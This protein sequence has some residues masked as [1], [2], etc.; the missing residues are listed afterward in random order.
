MVSNVSDRP[1]I[2]LTTYLEPS[3]HGVWDVVS[4]I[5][6]QAYLDGVSR[7]GGRPV[8]LPPQNAWTDDEID[9]LDGLILTGGADIDPGRYGQRPLPTSGTPQPGRDGSELDLL[10][11]AERKRLPVLG[12]C[13]GL[14]VIN[15]AHGGTLHQHLPDVLGH[16]GHQRAPGVFNDVSV[17]LEDGS[18]PAAW[19]GPEIT[20][21]CHHH[22]AIDQLGD[23][24]RVVGRAADGTIEALEDSRPGRFLVGVQWHPEE[25]LDDLAAFAAI[26]QAARQRRRDSARTDLEESA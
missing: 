24:L 13:R 21:R 2:G 17:K 23:D 4:A 6:P 14:Q 11:A 1:L 25:W 8:L 20:V 10:A 9:D 15:I 26:V 22:Q 3:R 12:I 18:M 19:H 7:A 5:L 16:T